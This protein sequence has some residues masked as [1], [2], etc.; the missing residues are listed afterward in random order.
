MD[1]NRN[2]H[3]PFF[4]FVFLRALRCLLN[5]QNLTMK[6]TKNT[7]E[8]DKE[9]FHFCVPCVYVTSCIL[10]LCVFFLSGCQGAG[11]STENPLSQL[12][13][14][15]PTAEPFG[16]TA[17]NHLALAEALMAGGHFE[18]ALS[19]LKKAYEQSPESAETAHLM[20]VCHRE[21]GSLETAADWFVRSNELDAAYAPTYNGMGLTLFHIGDL[22]AA[23][24]YFR[25]AVNLDP[26][27]A[28]FRNNLGYALM[29]A[30]R[31]D[32]AEPVLRRSLAVNAGL[33]AARNNL[34][35]CLGML[36]RDREALALLLETHPRATALR[37]M[38]AIYQ[39]RGETEKALAMAAK[40]D[41]LSGETKEKEI[42]H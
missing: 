17:P 4:V 28:G 21:L 36:Q 34:A 1:K 22:D 26:A 23:V 41:A 14:G 8:K 9:N 6:S 13:S 33:T 12:G 31:Y 32:E 25:Q 24:I 39:M 20:G 3:E 35:I 2:I 5:N 11:K 29:A 30:G 15:V 18:T 10:L 27:K 37:N 7:K 19:Q 38:G 16:D 42:D 40:A